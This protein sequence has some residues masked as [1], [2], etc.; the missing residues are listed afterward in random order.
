MTPNG[1]GQEIDGQFRHCRGSIMCT[2]GE[3]IFA[4]ATYKN[5]DGKTLRI[6]L[7]Q[8]EIDLESELLD[9]VKEYEFKDHLSKPHEEVIKYL[10]EWDRSTGYMACN[11]SYLLLRATPYFIGFELLTEKVVH[12]EHSESDLGNYDLT[13]DFF[14]YMDIC[15]SYS[16]LYQY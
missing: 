6:V 11:L 8:Y 13:K 1:T 4:L 7:E 2:D 10:E 15:S 14:Y 3:F 5:T 9:K 16:Y 12:N